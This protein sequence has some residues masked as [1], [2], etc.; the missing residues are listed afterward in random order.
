MASNGNGFN[1]TFTPPPVVL[2][3][4]RDRIQCDTTLHPLICPFGTVLF[5][6]LCPVC[7]WS[8]HNAAHGKQELRR[9]LSLGTP[10]LWKT[11]LWCLSSLVSNFRQWSVIK[12]P[13]SE[14]PNKPPH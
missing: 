7:S 2:L 9:F 8:N 4:L 13:L 11:K 14:F 3:F 1:S 12:T 6:F 5:Q 10:F